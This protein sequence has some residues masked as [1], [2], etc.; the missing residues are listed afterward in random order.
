MNGNYKISEIKTMHSD[1]F[2]WEHSSRCTGDIVPGLHIDE[3]GT[4]DLARYLGLS[5][6]GITRDRR[7]CNN[8]NDVAIALERNNGDWFWMHIDDYSF[9]PEG[10][11][12]FSSLDLSTCINLKEHYED[13]N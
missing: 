6:K 1:L 9:L 4:F 13:K 5:P 3:D 8:P 12:Q 7:I 2:D 11:K 10:I